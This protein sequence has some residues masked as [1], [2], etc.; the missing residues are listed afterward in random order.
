MGVD[1]IQNC[2]V[3]DFKLQRNG[4]SSVSTSQGQIETEKLALAVAGH[5]SH[6][7]AKAGIQLPLTCQT[8]QAMVS[9]PVKP[10]LDVVIDGAIYVSQSDHGELVVGG[11][12][13]AF[14]SFAQRG[15]STTVEE[16]FA[17]LVDLLPCISRMKWMRQWAGTVDYTPDHSPIIG[18]TPKRGLYLSGGWGSYGFKAIP[19]GGVTL[20]H[21]IATDTAH[22]LIE[23]FALERFETGALIDEGASSGMDMSVAIV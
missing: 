6:L 13:D 22:A 19:A 14:V 15:I 7:A 23:P 17:V 11:G 3:H 1:I 8:L 16:N 5:S 10:M 21:T 4:I 20:A 18:K 12:S 9:E 2:T